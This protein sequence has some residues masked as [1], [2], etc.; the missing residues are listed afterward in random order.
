M[1]RKFQGHEFELRD[2]RLNEWGLDASCN[3]GRKRE[4]LLDYSRSLV[5]PDLDLHNSPLKGSIKGSAFLL[6]NLRLREV[7]RLP[8]DKQLDSNIASI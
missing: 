1:L 7:K 6:G 2:A 3:Y 4:N 8:K 5:H